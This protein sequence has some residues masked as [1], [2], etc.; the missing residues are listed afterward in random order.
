M[1]RAFSN[2]PATKRVLH[3]AVLLWPHLLAS[4]LTSPHLLVGCSRHLLLAESPPACSM[5]DD[6]LNKQMHVSCQPSH[7]GH[8]RKYSTCEQGTSLGLREEQTR[9]CAPLVFIN[10]EPY[11]LL[12]SVTL[13]INP[14]AKSESSHSLFWRFIVKICSPPTNAFITFSSVP[15]PWCGLQLMLSTYVYK[16]WKYFWY[17]VHLINFLLLLC[18]FVWRKIVS[19]L[20]FYWSAFGVMI[21]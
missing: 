12:C 19:V 8:L 13:T 4:F 9:T 15:C 2:E 1:L 17:N 16:H 10:F 5:F 18:L 7:W 3:L 14:Q 11:S 6:I 20:M 21:S